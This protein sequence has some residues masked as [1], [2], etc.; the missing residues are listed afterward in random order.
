MKAYLQ[1]ALFAIFIIGIN[2]DITLCEAVSGNL[3][4]DICRMYP[5][6]MDYTHC[7]YVEM[8]GNG[9]CRQLKDDE[10]E[11]VKRYKDFL[12][13]QGN[14]DIKIKCS[15]EFLTYSLLALLALIF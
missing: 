7:C 11:N 1:I 12:K 14:T 10:Y 6:E 8:N 4:E 13:S 2:G 15:G 9:Q 3:D 5:T